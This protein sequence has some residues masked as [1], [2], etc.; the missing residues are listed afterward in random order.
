MKIIC[1]RNGQEIEFKYGFPLWVKEVEGI[2][3]TKFDIQTEKPSDSGQDKRGHL[4][5][6]QAKKPRHSRY[7]G[8]PGRN[9]RDVGSGGRSMKIN[10]KVRMKNPVFW[11]QVA[12][13]VVGPILAYLGLF[14]GGH[15]HLGG[16]WGNL[17]EGHLQ[18]RGDCVG[19]WCR[20][21]ISSPTR[22]PKV[23]GTANRH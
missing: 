7:Y 19:F 11:A 17:C 12:V 14:L 4:F 1:K 10:W 23:L 3:E 22:P 18:P 9:E 20:C 13:A 15:D 16:F 2:S 8:K 5:T 21:G 6:L